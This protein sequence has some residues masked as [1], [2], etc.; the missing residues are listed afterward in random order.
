MKGFLSIVLFLFFLN[1]NV[2]GVMVRGIYV[3]SRNSYQICESNR[4]QS[5]KLFTLVLRLSFFRGEKVGSN[6]P[7]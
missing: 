1:G 5:S 6:S 4:E 3:Q 7:L 2:L